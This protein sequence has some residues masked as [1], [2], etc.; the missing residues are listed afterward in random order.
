MIELGG[1]TATGIRIPPKMVEALGTSKWPAVRVTI[2][3]YTYHGT[4]AV[5]GGEFM[6]GVSAEVR[7]KAGVAAGDLVDVDLDLDFDLDLDAQHREVTVPPDLAKALKT[8]PDA[9]R[10]FE[11]LSFSNKQWHVLSIEG[12]KTAETRQRRIA[13]SVSTPREGRPR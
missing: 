10:T 7:E 4:V 12:A 5:M 8:E 2:N 11:G 6:L 1:K 9:K 3:G 13:R